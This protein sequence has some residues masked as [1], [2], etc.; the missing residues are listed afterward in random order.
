MAPRE[1]ARL[2]ISLA[3]AVW[4]QYWQSPAARALGISRGLVTGWIEGRCDARPAHLSNMMTIASAKMAEIEG[5]MHL[6]LG[7]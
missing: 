4:G 6:A 3:S 2:I 5:V 7:E 1:R